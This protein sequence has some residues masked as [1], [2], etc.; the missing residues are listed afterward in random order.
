[1]DKAGQ[2][3]LAPAFD[4]TYSY[5]PNGMWTATHQMTLNG[6]RDNF[7]L[8]DFRAC[9]KVASMKR[10]RAEVII[11]EV[12][13]VVARWPEY[14][15]AAGVPGPVRDQVGKVLRLENGVGR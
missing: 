9:A 12:R 3:S 1:M 6:K 2:W 14:A 15:D 8:E 10:G 7:D 5:N 11:D 13:S 4:V